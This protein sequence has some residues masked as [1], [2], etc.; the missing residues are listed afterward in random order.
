MVPAPAC[1]PLA[2]LVEQ[3][4]LNQRVG[5]SSPPRPTNRI[6]HFQNIGSARCAFCYHF[7]TALV[8]EAIHRCLVPHRQPLPVDVDSE[9]NGGVAELTLHV[10][11]TLPLLEEQRGECVAEAMQGRLL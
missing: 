11:G 2:Q 5:G 8:V 7:A 9:L 1:G 4:T 3:L 10:G 6:G